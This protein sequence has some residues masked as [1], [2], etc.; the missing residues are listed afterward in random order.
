MS[1]FF[2]SE[3]KDKLPEKTEVKK[4]GKT[5]EADKDGYVL[6]VQFWK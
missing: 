5:E 1:T 6:H 2:S 3:S 4:N